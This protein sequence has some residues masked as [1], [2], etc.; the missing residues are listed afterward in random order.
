MI[1]ITALLLCRQQFDDD[2]VEFSKV[3]QDRVLGTSGESATV[4]IQFFDLRLK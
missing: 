4:S 3:T 2:H 1:Y